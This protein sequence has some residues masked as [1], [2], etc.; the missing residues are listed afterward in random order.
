M[1]KM[2]L[3]CINIFIWFLKVNFIFHTFVKYLIVIKLDRKKPYKN[4]SI[5]D[6]TLKGIH[7]V[8]LDN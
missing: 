2:Q 3:F 5:Q 4:T 8:R 6:K 1:S 7:G